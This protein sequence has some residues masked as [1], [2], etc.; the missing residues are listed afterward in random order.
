MSS[1]N[2]R[3]RGPLEDNTLQAK[4]SDKSS[5]EEE[6]ENGDEY[7]LEENADSDEE[8]DEEESQPEDEN[9]SDFTEEDEDRSSDQKTEP[10]IKKGKVKRKFNDI[11][12]GENQ[13]DNQYVLAKQPKK[14]KFIKK[15]TFLPPDSETGEP[16]RLLVFP[17]LLTRKVE[18]E[19]AHSLR[20]SG[21]LHVPVRPPPPNSLDKDARQKYTQEVKARMKLNESTRKLYPKYSDATAVALI[22]CCKAAKIPV[23]SN[24]EKG[25]KKSKYRMRPWR[26]FGHATCENKRWVLYKEEV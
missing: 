3:K 16:G 23:P 22:D 20:A 19:I 14:D 4:S 7:E 5:A 1:R 2:L 8:E 10:V 24:L 13:E 15:V 18:K 11:E 25:I 17:E 6:I 9:D 12:D 21:T 26:F